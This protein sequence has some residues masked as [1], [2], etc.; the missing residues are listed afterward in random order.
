MKFMLVVNDHLLCMVEAPTVQ[1]AEDLFSGKAGV[2]SVHGYDL[3]GFDLSVYSTCETVGYGELNK[4][5][6]QYAYLD[7]IIDLHPYY[8][9]LLTF[10]NIQ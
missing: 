4:L 7:R 2:Q 8:D 10:L 9:S 5:L 6:N 1:K 3:S